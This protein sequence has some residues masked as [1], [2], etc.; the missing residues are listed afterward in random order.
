MISQ[1]QLIA[2]TVGLLL[3]GQGMAQSVEPT[4][5]GQ[6]YQSLCAA[7]HMPDGRG[8]GPYPAIRSNPSV[9][10]GGAGFVA[11]RVAN[12]YGAM[13]PFCR[14]ASL[15]VIAEVSNWVASNLDNAATSPPISA[16]DVLNLMPTATS[17]PK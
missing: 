13:V 12:G 11:Y 4:D 14:L 2:L 16:N 17:C 8:A 5:G 7:C 10:L 6:L 15:Q 1:V 3:A 9:R